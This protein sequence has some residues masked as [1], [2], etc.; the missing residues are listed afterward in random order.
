MYCLV[1]ALT[2][3]IIA[4]IMSTNYISRRVDRTKLLAKLKDFK[5]AFSRNFEA[6]RHFF[7]KC[8]VTLESSATPKDFI[9]NLEIKVVDHINNL[10]FLQ[11]LPNEFNLLD[12][13]NYKKAVHGIKIPMSYGATIQ[14]NSRALLAEIDSLTN[15][16]PPIG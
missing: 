5:G 10:P 12:Y 8:A 16:K 3:L 4:F 9:P 2:H 7:R 1:S 13:L 11:D 6:V 15:K 14:A